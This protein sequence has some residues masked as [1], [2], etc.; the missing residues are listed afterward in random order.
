MKKKESLDKERMFE[1]EQNSLIEKTA[2]AIADGELLIDVQIEDVSPVHYHPWLSEL[3]EKFKLEEELIFTEQ[4]IFDRAVLI[5]SR[6][7]TLGYTGRGFLEK[8]I[9]GNVKQF[10][11]DIDEYAVDRQFDENHVLNG[12]KIKLADVTAVKLMNILL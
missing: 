5:H 3:R 10:K 9:N 11:K 12:F 1:L 4:V 7:G 8:A 6:R 2:R